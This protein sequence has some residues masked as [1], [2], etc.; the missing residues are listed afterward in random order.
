LRDIGRLFQSETEE[1]N[2]TSV[3]H[4]SSAH[5][6]VGDVDPDIVEMIRAGPH[7]HIDESPEADPYAA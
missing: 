4:A 3:P 2:S 5:G 6:L 1:F 7:A